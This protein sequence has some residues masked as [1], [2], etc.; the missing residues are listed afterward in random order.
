MFFLS[1]HCGTFR[2]LRQISS[3]IATPTIGGKTWSTPAGGIPVPKGATVAFDVVYC[4][5]GRVF[6]DDNQGRWYIAD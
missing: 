6:T 2:F 5:D 1:H 4:V 3:L